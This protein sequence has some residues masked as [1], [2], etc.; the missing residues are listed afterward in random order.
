MSALMRSLRERPVPLSL[1]ALAVGALSLVLVGHPLASTQA[2]N[3]ARTASPPT[4]ML[5]QGL[6]V[7]RAPSSSIDMP[8][9]G[10]LAALGAIDLSA[11]T[12]LARRAMITAW[13]AAVYLVPTAD[14]VCLI[15]DT[16][17]ETG[18]FTT[19]AVLGADATESDDCSPGLPNDNTIEIAGVMPD[20]AVNPVVVLTDG[21][22]RP[23][24]VK[25]NTYVARF[26]R[27]G[28]LPETIES[29]PAGGRTSTSAGV[30][31]GVAH[32][33]CVVSAGELRK[34]EAS[35]KIPR[36]LGHPPAGPLGG[37]EYNRG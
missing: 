23:L 10:V 19:A 35:G 26:A 8:P 6:A 31:S 36:A 32:E 27:N 7:L 5:R 33:A 34:L 22:R 9:A 28:P 13:G 1:A 20:S 30:P 29:G 24:S 16:L 2:P 17:T 12:R 11:N 14:G 37:V 21:S 3:R 25:H 15:D 18:C 4:T